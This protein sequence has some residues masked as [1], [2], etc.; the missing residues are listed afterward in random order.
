MPDRTALQNFYSPEAASKYKQ[1]MQAKSELSYYLTDIENLSTNSLF[2]PTAP[3]LDCGCGTGDLLNLCIKS[4]LPPT[5][6]KIGVDISENMLAHSRTLIP[7]GKFITGDVTSLQ[8]SDINT[9]TIGG[10]ICTFVTHH[11]TNDE[12]IEA[13]KEFY[14][15]MKTNAHIYHCY[16]QGSGEM[17]AFTEPTEPVTL[18]KRESEYVDK[19][20]EEEGFKKV[21]GRSES[22][23]WG[24]MCFD[25]YVK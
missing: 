18:L 16:W 17:E 11:L 20:F 1:I 9:D 24:D 2:L 8:E 12:L 6:E 15:V 25:I 4:G 21:S 10:I 5:V 22:Y 7:D 3:L 14:R 19:V 23:E 13:V